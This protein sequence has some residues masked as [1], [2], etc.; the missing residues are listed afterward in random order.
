MDE[1]KTLKRIAELFPVLSKSLKKGDCGR[2][3]V[4]GGSDVY[5]GAPYFSAVTPSRIGADLVYVHTHPFAAP[6]I[7]SFSPELIVHPSLDFEDVKITLGRVDGII[8]GPGLGREKPKLTNLLKNV[9]EFVKNTPKIS[10]VIDADGLYLILDC[11]TQVRGCS[12]I[13]LTPNFREFERL[14]KHVFPNSH[15]SEHTEKVKYLASNLAINVF[16]KG[17][18][19]VI[20]DGNTVK[21]GQLET[22]LRRCGG[23]GDIL[24]GVISLFSFWSFLRD[25]S[26]NALNSKHIL[27]ASFAASDFQR[28][29]SRRTFQKIGRSMN[30]S[31]I[32]SEIPDF[33][34]ELDKLTIP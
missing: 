6:V 11:L 18:N 2:I 9:I 14:Y 5:T 24:S 1:V 17:E 3:C 26:C 23:Q 15:D 16:A 21:L 19:D 28:L 4:I 10:L 20:T 30:A 31:D 27:E 7:K 12:N 34:R 8:F 29:V 22:S 33:V 32:I 25:K 13:I